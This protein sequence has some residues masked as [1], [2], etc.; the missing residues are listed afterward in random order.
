MK[1]SVLKD[2]H[3]FCVHVIDPKEG[4]DEA[5]QEEAPKDGLEKADV[6]KSE[7]EGEYFETNE[8]MELKSL[9]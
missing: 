5:D 6:E 1:S 7:K 2:G 8:S 9:I 4:G 3:T